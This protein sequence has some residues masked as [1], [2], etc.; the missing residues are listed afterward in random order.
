MMIS[1]QIVPLA[2]Q[3]SYRGAPFAWIGIP[4]A[5]IGIIEWLER[6]KP[7]DPYEMENILCI[8]EN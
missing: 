4:I 8:P 7:E 3:L 5:A 1:L 2:L 6:G